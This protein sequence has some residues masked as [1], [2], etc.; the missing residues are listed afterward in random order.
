MTGGL[1]RR[2]LLKAVTAMSMTSSPNRRPFGQPPGTVP[3]PKPA[4][5]VLVQ[6]FFDLLFGERFSKVPGIIESDGGLGHQAGA[7]LTVSHQ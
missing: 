6:F 5:T 2:S 3:P 4:C 1:T 7:E